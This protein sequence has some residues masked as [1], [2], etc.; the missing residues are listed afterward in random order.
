MREVN[1]PFMTTIVKGIAN[2]LTHSK[3]MNVVVKLVM[4]YLDHIAMDRS[5]EVLKPGRGKI[6]VCLRKHNAKQITLPKWT[7]VGE[8]AAISV[9]PA[10]LALKPTKDESGKVKPP[11]VKGKMR[12]RKNCWKKLT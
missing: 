1:S 11:L 2:L 6:D 8:T 4:G 9:I 3:C 5:Y 7:S 10:L 12:V